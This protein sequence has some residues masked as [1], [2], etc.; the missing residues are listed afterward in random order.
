MA[1]PA[2]RLDSD[3][4]P[5]AWPQ[6]ISRDPIFTIGQVVEQLSKEF[7]TVSVSK[8]RYW[9]DQDLVKPHRTGAGYRKYSQADIERLRY[10]L[11]RQR[12]SF[13]PLRVIADDLRALDAGHK[14]VE[15]RAHASLVTSEGS[16][17]KLGDRPAIPVRDLAD[18]TGVE[19]DTLDRYTRLGLITPDLGG[20]FNARTVQVVTLLVKLESLGLD[21]RLL[22]TIRQSAERGSDIIDQTVSSQRA[23]HRSADKERAAA[24]AM[25]MGE[26]V[27][28]LYK[29]MMRVSVAHLNDTVS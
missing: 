19:V 21:A 26:I 11:A 22:R 9:E 14:V 3:Q 2:R 6:G 24:R 23:R 16:L 28:D 25:E 15:V 20:Y 4:S 27:S 18:M 7:P 12:D 5:E 17:V 8:I 1:L 10:V 29:E 13:A